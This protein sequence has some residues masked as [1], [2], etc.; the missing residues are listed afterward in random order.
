M[1]LKRLTEELQRILSWI[2]KYL[3]FIPFFSL[4]LYK[5][6][7]LSEC[8]LPSEPRLKEPFSVK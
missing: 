2:K 4:F 8:N 5:L 3:T 6:L 1:S 7:K